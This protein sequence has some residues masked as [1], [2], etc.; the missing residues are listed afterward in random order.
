MKHTIIKCTK[1]DYVFY[2]EDFD[3][4]R[5][6]DRCTCGNIDMGTKVAEDSVYKWY[7]TISYKDE[8]PEI[9]ESD[10]K[11]DQQIKP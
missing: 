6:V 3:H 7:V 1:C 4:E 9:F 10:T 5:M 2:K 8:R 11:I